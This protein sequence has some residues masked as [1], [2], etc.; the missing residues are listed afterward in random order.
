MPEANSTSEKLNSVSHPY[1]NLIR[2]VDRCPVALGLGAC[3]LLGQSFGTR[4]AGI[5]SVAPWPFAST[6]PP[7]SAAMRAEARAA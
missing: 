5:P 3:A 4:L 1:A 2:L 6:S 7:S